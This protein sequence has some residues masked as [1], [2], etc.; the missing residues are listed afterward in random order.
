MWHSAH[1]PNN[2]A[3]E[4]YEIQQ[5]SQESKNRS[6]SSSSAYEN[7]RYLVDKYAP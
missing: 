6:N 2:A 1:Y 3:R 7:L 5:I 4:R